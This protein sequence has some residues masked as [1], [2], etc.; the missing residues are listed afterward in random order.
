MKQWKQGILA[1]ALVMGM[2]IPDG[3]L[4]AGSA[5]ASAFPTVETRAAQA[6]G[7]HG[8]HKLR[9]SMNS[10]HKMYM[11]LLA[12]KYTPNSAGEWQAAF[13]ERERLLGELKAARETSGENEKRAAK[14]EEKKQLIAKL[15]EQ[16]KKGEITSEQMEQQVK[17]WKEKNFGDRQNGQDSENRKA[18]MEQFKQ[19][20]EDFNAAIES[21]DAA[22]IK[23]VL[24]K[25][26]EQL[27]ARNAH[28]AQKLAEMK[29]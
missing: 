18:M 12:E 16:V 11:M 27:K 20:R 7:D 6:H 19:T 1:T 26:L 29:K 13:T 21:G 28:L 15:S 8:H 22:K 2:A 9:H 4:A 10:H 14:R 3:V 25:M 17:E 23:E 5:T 24:P